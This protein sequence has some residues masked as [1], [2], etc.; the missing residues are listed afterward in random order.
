M[1]RVL[2][3]GLSTLVIAA[4]VGSSIFF[5]SKSVKAKSD[6][7]LQLNIQAFSIRY[8]SILD[9]IDVSPDIATF[10]NVPVFVWTENI[11]TPNRTILHATAII[12]GIA[13]EATQTRDVTD[14][15]RGIK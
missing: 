3:I 11:S 9:Q 12:N 10:N 6:A 13:Y 1:K 2:I 8:S 4:S 15:L 5:Y 14:L 7:E